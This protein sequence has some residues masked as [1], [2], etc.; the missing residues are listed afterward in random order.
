M[1]NRTFSPLPELLLLGAG[2]QGVCALGTE[3]LAVVNIEDVCFYT[4]G[5]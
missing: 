4:K 2:P 1:C 3:I 5:L